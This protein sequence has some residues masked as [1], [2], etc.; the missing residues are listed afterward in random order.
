MNNLILK[1]LFLL[2]FQKYSFNENTFG[3]CML[4]TPWIQTSDLI[5][6]YSED[7]LKHIAINQDSAIS[8]LIMED[9]KPHKKYSDH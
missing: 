4:H 3:D 8:I 9:T 5:V 7:L 1:T 6:N 2:I